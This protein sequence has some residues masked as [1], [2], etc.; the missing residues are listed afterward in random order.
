MPYFSPTLSSIVRALS[1]IIRLRFSIALPVRS[2]PWLAAD[3]ALVS[4]RSLK[5]PV[6][7][8]LVAAALVAPAFS[9]AAFCAVVV[10]VSD[11]SFVAVAFFAAGFFAAALA[12]VLAVD[13]FTSAMIDIPSSIVSCQ[14]PT[15]RKRSICGS[16]FIRHGIICFGIK[17]EGGD[18]S[19]AM[20][21]KT[22]VIAIRPWPSFLLFRSLFP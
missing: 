15:S 6:A 3:L 14:H 5:S 9:G 17:G 12:G 21:C 2:L 10:R 16:R 11:V 22:P 20:D 4:A 7:F 1:S 18:K 8:G 13:F 19:C